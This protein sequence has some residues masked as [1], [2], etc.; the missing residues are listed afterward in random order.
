MGVQSVDTDAPLA[1]YTSLL[2]NRIFVTVH[3][4]KQCQSLG[5]VSFLSNSIVW[6]LFTFEN[7]SICTTMLEYEP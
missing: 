3:Q 1:T 5:M 7:M 2:A 6:I 4:N